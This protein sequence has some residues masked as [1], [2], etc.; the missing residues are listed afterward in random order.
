MTQRFFADISKVLHH[1]VAI[2]GCNLGDCYDRNT[3]PITSLGMQAWGIPISAIKMLLNTQRI[4]KFCLRTGFGESKEMFGGPD[5]PP[6]VGSGQGN[7]AAPPSCLCLGALI[8]N[9]CK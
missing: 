9:A 8:V 5:A 7:G 4:M 6:S 1:P 3:H 2:E